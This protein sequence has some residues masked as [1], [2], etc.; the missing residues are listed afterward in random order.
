M[1]NWYCCTQVLSHIARKLL[2]HRAN[3]PQK[4][5]PYKYSH[6]FISVSWLTKMNTMLYF[7]ALV[8]QPHLLFRS[9]FLPQCDSHFDSHSW[10]I[11]HPSAFVKNSSHIVCSQSDK[12][13]I[14]VELFKNL[15]HVVK[16]I[17]IRNEKSRWS[18][19]FSIKSNRQ[20][21][22]FSCPL[23]K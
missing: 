15:S 10:R 12:M 11:S 2:C 8:L 13:Q 14:G 5:V 21:N 6:L 20:M 7:G 16:R 22:T 3:N 18:S 4:L 9:G 19:K 17:Q 1:L 23:H